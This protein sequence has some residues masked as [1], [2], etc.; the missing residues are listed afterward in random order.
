MKPCT[1]RSR[2]LFGI[3]ALA[4]TLIV[5]PACSATA[6]H[7]GAAANCPPG[8][9]PS[10]RRSFRPIL[11]QLPSRTFYLAGYAGAA[12]P[13]VGQRVPIDPTST[14]AARRPIFPRLLGR[15]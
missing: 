15:P 9:Q 4:A 8:S 11:S 7:H 6:Q 3:A 5:L 2:A 1:Y 10:G 13:P 12:Y 14:R